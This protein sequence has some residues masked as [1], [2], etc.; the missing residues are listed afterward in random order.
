MDYFQGV[1]TEYLRADRAVFVNTECLIQLEPGDVPAKGKHWYCDAVA[2]NFRE[3]IVYLCEVTYSTTMQSLITRLQGWET[4]WASLCAALARD[5]AIPTSWVIQPWLFIPQEHHPTLNKK[6]SAIVKSGLATNHMPNP[7]VTYLESVTPWK[8]R[9]W[10]RR[11]SA[12]E[13]DKS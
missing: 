2:V 1:V 8:Y 5:C 9:T 13:N 7:K 6:L 12:F 4:H 10:D 3:S 11:A